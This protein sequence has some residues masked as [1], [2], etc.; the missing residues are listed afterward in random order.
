MS[1]ADESKNVKDPF[2]FFHLML[3]VV[4]DVKRAPTFSK[5]G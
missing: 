2:I 3:E 5:K 1:L 4:L